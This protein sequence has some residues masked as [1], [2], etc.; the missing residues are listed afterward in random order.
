MTRYDDRIR[1]ALDEDDKAFLASLDA[2]HGLFSQIGDTFAGPLGGWAKLIFGGSLVLG[3]AM[4]YAF[5]RLLDAPEPHSL[6]GWGMVLLGL[7]IAQGFIKEW[8]FNRMNLITTLR[9]IKRLQLQ[10]AELSDRLG[11]NR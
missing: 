8:F 2:N 4:L 11:E 6:L 5:I 10:V 7:L 9:E 3:A 1:G